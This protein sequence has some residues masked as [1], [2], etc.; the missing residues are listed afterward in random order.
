MKLYK[1]KKI[2]FL[3]LAACIVLAI[4]LTENLIDLDHEAT[5]IWEDCF[6]CLRI[7]SVKSFIKTLTL[8]AMIHMAHILVYQI[9]ANGT[10]SDRNIIS[11]S[12]IT[13]KVRSN[14]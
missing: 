4:V 1:R 6:V 5:C 11:L 9:L 2:L 14:S 13:L 7:E 8:A 3:L 12:P 10:L